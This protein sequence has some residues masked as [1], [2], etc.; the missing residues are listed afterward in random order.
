MIENLIL[1]GLLGIV[2]QLFSTAFQMSR[3]VDFEGPLGKR[4]IAYLFFVILCV[5]TGIFI[6]TF[7]LILRFQD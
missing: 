6:L 4:E 5:L 7:G 1:L 2:I 3:R